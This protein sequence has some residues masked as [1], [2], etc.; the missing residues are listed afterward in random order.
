[1]TRADARRA[2][3]GRL[4]GEVAM[5]TGAAGG[6]GSVVARSLA[7]QGACVAAVDLPGARLAAVA[8]DGVDAY[9]ADVRST[10]EVVAAV[11]QIERERGHIG[12]LVNTAGILRSGSVA[13]LSDDDWSD[14][15]E[16]NLHGVVRCCRAVA[17]GMAARGRGAIVTIG[18]N[19][20]GVPRM[21]LAAYAASKAAAAH[22]MRCLGLELAGQGVR[23]NV[24]S[25]GSTD[26]GML[27]ELMGA[28]ATR[29][30]VAG[31]PDQ[32]RVGIPL[33]RIAE[34]ADVAAAV[35][36]LVS[37]AARHI[38]LQ[39]LYVDGGAGLGR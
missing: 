28:A 37:D 9:P 16:V 18:S 2:R 25:P 23:C 17:V 34:P 10:A 38:T 1:M 4:R 3:S 24:V 12:I 19:A 13:H 20:G 26:T 39:D 31:V 8:V 15:F 22:F 32:F 6:I 36:F 11:A 29:D 5:V 35:S 14:V 27:R 21:N 33:R 7:D 30:V